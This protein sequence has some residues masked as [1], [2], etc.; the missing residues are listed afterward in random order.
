MLTGQFQSNAD[1]PA[2]DFRRRLPRFQPDVFDENLKLTKAVTKVAE[3]KGVTVGQVALG[4]VLAKGALPI[5]GSTSP[6]RVAEN[7]KVVQLSAAEIVEIEAIL[8]EIPVTG[9]RYDAS[10][11][12]YL[13]G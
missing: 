6:A 4:W 9:D 13:H 1:L 11:Q 3:R 5:P 2:N 10:Q 8:K 7:S 12:K